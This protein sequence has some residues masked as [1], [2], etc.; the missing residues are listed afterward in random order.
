MMSPQN[1]Q[2]E[3]ELMPS[4]VTLWRQRLRWQRGALE[5][6]ATYGITAATTRYWSQQ[7]GIAYSIFA[8]WSF[9]LLIFLQVVSLDGWVWFPYWLAMG[10]VFALERVHTV[11]QGGWKARFLALALFPEL[12]YDSFLDLVFLKGVADM[13][14][15]RDA[16]WGHERVEARKAMQFHELKLE[17][18]DES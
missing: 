15:K 16:Q 17:Q 5:N 3:T 13:A 8:L 2:V 12:L 7:L 4:A 10:G 18:A 11:W 1:C 14:L 9:F 6:I